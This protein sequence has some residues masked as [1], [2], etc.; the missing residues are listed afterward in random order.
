MSTCCTQT[1]CGKF[2]NN[3]Y[4]LFSSKRTYEQRAECLQRGFQTRIKNERLG[5]SLVKTDE[6]GV[7][8][9]RVQGSV[10]H[11]H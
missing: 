1:R 7:R 5:H 8:V 2:L 10:D 3:I 9:D 4:L 11:V 6:L